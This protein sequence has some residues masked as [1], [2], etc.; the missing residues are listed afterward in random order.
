MR[1]S[2]SRSVRPTPSNLL[3]IGRKE[4]DLHFPY[5]YCT[6]RLTVAVSLA[7]FGSGVFDIVAGLP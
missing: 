4:Q 1:T 3:L 2:A 7:M 5:L 6:L